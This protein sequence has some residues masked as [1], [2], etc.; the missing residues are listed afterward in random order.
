MA[1]GLILLHCL[2][3]HPSGK[4][5]SR[6]DSC[7]RLGKLGLDWLPRQRELW[8]CWSRWSL[9][10]P[11]WAGVLTEAQCWKMGMWFNYQ[12]LYAEAAGVFYVS[13]RRQQAF[14]YAAWFASEAQGPQGKAK[15]SSVPLIP[16]NDSIRFPETVVALAPDLAELWLDI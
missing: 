5:P 14:R 2:A 1:A 16:A 6:Q 15:R 9:A 11:L 8:N 7:R 3:A 13:E 4:I 10:A 12:T